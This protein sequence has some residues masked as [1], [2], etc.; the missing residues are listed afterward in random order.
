MRQT[1]PVLKLRVSALVAVAAAAVLLYAGCG[2]DSDN[3]AGEVSPELSKAL[4][5]LPPDAGFALAA[6]QD[7]ESGPVKDLDSRFSGVDGWDEV[8]EE[9]EALFDDDLDFERDIRPQLGPPGVYSASSLDDDDPAELSAFQVKDPA[10]MRRAMERLVSSE[11]AARA[12]SHSGALIVRDQDFDPD[13]DFEF[14]ALHDGVFRGRCP[15]YR[16]VLGPGA[17]DKP[18]DK[19]THGPDAAEEFHDRP[20]RLCLQFQEHP[21]YR[22]AADH[23]R[24]AAG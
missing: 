13:Q 22:P 21:V 24:G 18:G 15:L 8:K 5:Y 16:H 1:G 11:E 17:C 12:G 2:G 7:P 4:S 3:D 19:R 10:A 6:A 20:W 9:I 14:T 23:H